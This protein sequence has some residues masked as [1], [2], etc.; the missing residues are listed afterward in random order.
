MPSFGQ[1]E[2]IKLLEVNE[3]TIASGILPLSFGP[4]TAYGNYPSVI[5]E[6]TREEFDKIKSNELKLPHCWKIGEMIPKP[7]MVPADGDC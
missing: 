2:P 7:Q 1:R 5:L 3:N 4:A 6:V